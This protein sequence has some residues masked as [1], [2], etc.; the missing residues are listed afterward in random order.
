MLYCF[1]LLPQ[2]STQFFDVLVCKITLYME[3][4]GQ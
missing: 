3:P 4:T 1:V 2:T